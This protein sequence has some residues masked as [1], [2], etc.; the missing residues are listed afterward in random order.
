LSAEL[1]EKAGSLILSSDPI[2]SSARKALLPLHRAFHPLSVDLAPSANVVKEWPL[3][4][5]K[6]E[7]K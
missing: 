4:V 1:P 3:I 2:G 5:R 7:L 6:A